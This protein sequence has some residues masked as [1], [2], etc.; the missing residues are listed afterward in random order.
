MNVRNCPRCNRIFVPQGRRICP[1][2]VRED[3]EKYER[4]REFL[5]D[6]PGATLLEVIA[7]TEVDEDTVLQFIKEGRI[8]ASQ[9]QGASL[10]C[11]RCDAPISS[12]TLCPSCQGAL[13]KELQ[14]AAGSL[15]PSSPGERETKSRPKDKM[16]TADMKD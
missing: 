11:E 5:R 7:A 14:K 8:E 16:F 2:C 9:L 3:E 15:R 12:G 1:V 10:H 4:V 6:H 13:A